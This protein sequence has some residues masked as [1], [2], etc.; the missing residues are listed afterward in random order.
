MKISVIGLR[1][2]PSDYGGLER[3]AQ[4]LYPKLVSRGYEIT[5]F[6]RNK[7][8]IEKNSEGLLVIKTPYTPIFSLET[9][10]H[11]FS[12]FFHILKYHKKTDVVHIHA[13]APGV[14]C[15]FFNILNI[16]SVVSIQGLDWKRAKWSGL[17][18]FLL[19]LCERVTIKFASEVTVVSEE[20][21]EYYKNKYKRVTH[22]IPNAIDFDKQNQK[23]EQ[24]RLDSNK[25]MQ[26][27][28]VL[29]F[30]RLVPEKRIE[31][32]IQAFKLIHSDVQLNIAGTGP[33]KYVEYLLKIASSDSRIQF[34]GHQKRKS[35]KEW[36]RNALLVVSA[37]E[38]EGLPLALIEAIAMSIPII[39]SDIQP[40]RELFIGIDNEDVFFNQYDIK[41]LS[42][43]M[44]KVLTN[45][46]LHKQKA[47]FYRDNCLLKNV[48]KMVDDIE[49]TLIKAKSNL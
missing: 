32:V 36:I 37:S 18:G 17:G 6:T 7:D 13:I 23:E 47:I 10:S 40:H 28:Y 30:S 22:L 19:K 4:E 41:G 12:S 9:L 21:Q 2:F 15:L 43:K 39:A 14:L 44:D 26:E 1:G 8:D 46:S 45:Y 24:S 42:I 27:K 35:I 34:I 20:L 3:V 25:R 29:C 33:K 49:K 31:D 16:P 38:L 11:A 5:I 48:E